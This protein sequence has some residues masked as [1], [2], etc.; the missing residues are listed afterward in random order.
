M[1]NNHVDATAAYKIWMAFR[2]A[3]EKKAFTDPTLIA[4][5][6]EEEEAWQDAYVRLS[7]GETV[8]I[9]NELGIPRVD[10]TNP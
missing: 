2:E 6:E 4:I 9:L 5:C 3:L 7:D 1:N 10:T 8:S